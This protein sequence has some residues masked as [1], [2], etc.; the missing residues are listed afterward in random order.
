MQARHNATLL[1]CLVIQLAISVMPTSQKQR[2]YT[3]TRYTLKLSRRHRTEVP[4]LPTVCIK[5]KRLRYGKGSNLELMLSTQFSAYR[6]NTNYTDLFV[7]DNTVHGPQQ[8][9]TD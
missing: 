5:H 8:S 9:P 7:T 4:L 3:D 1:I 2:Q 6:Q